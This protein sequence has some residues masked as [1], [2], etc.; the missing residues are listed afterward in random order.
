MA[1][2]GETARPENKE[3]KATVCAIP[4]LGP[5]LGIAPDGQ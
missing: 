1:M 5:S 3:I 4:E 2:V